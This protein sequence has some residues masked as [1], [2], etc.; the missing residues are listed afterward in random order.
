MNPLLTKNHTSDE[1]LNRTGLTGKADRLEN[2]LE[3][4]FRRIGIILVK[5]GKVLN[6]K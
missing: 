3:R 5:N 2:S 4:R 6:L 1:I